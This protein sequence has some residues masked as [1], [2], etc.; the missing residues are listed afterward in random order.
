[1]S[2]QISGYYEEL[3]AYAR[4]RISCGRVAEDIVQDTFARALKR[5]DLDCVE[6]PRAYLYQILINL[7]RDH[8]RRESRAFQVLPTDLSSEERILDS[9]PSPSDCLSAQD[10]QDQVRA[11]LDGLP[12]K[13][14]KVLVLKRFHGLRQRE[15]A[16]RLGISESTV[17]KHLAKALCRLRQSLSDLI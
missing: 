10:I 4:K 17:E 14:R 16:E 12:P 15:I 2:N 13:C 9:Q 8:W 7:I 6:Q 1:M 5:H 11:A 3:Y